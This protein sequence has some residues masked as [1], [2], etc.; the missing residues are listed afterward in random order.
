MIPFDLTK[1]QG[2]ILEILPGRYRKGLPAETV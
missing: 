1:D 2:S